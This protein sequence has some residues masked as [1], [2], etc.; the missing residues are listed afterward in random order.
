[1]S[2]VLHILYLLPFVCNTNPAFP[3][4]D[5]PVTIVPSAPLADWV[6]DPHTEVTTKG[7]PGALDP[8]TE[9]STKAMLGV[10]WMVLVV[11]VVL[12]FLCGIVM[13]PKGFPVKQQPTP[14]MPQDGRFRRDRYGRFISKDGHNDYVELKIP[15]LKNA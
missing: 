15:R 13:L 14:T 10:G 4:Q 12:M 8:H 6:R 9:V 7:M 2:P 5:Q 1:M 11:T 3:S